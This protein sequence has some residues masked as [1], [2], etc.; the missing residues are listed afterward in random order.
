MKR[1]DVVQGHD[2]RNGKTFWQKLGS[3]FEGDDGK[4]WMEFTALPLADKEGRVRMQCFEP[5]QDGQRQ[6][7]AGGSAP[8]D[9]G[10]PF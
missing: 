9:D 3:L 7:Q 2:G 8:V 10:V 5:R 4:M 6:Q 1:W